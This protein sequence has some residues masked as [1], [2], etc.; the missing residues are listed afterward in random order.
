MKFVEVYSSG[1]KTFINPEHIVR[2]IA[3]G[4]TEDQ[5]TCIVELA[6]RDCAITVQM[7]CERLAYLC[8]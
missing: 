8:H 4:L 5:D 7:S 6:D 3:P 1:V 2:I